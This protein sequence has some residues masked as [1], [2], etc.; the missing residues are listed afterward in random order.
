MV[1]FARRKVKV[2]YYLYY[3]CV[4]SSPTI[5]G[6]SD[7]FRLAGIGKDLEESKLNGIRCKSYCRS[8]W[9]H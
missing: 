5:T 7:C 3:I 9:T 8:N 2:F 4:N 1:S 6:V